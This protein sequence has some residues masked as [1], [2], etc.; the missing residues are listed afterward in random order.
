MSER[1]GES[2][3]SK[4]ELR[5]IILAGVM[6]VL[7]IVPRA[8]AEGERY[9]KTGETDKYRWECLSRSCINRTKA[10]MRFVFDDGRV[11]EYEGG[12]NEKGQRH[13]CQSTSKKN[14]R[15]YYKGPWHD[16]K[17]D[18]RACDNEGAFY[19]SSGNVYVGGWRESKEHGPGLYTLASGARYQ[20]EWRYGK[21]IATDQIH[22]SRPTGGS[23]NGNSSTSSKNYSWIDYNTGEF[24][25][26]GVNKQQNNRCK[27]NGYT[28]L[29]V[30]ACKEAV[31]SVCNY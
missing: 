26:N 14:G 3:C 30:D 8:E 27:E 28:W 17:R 22:D 7:G 20:Q 23:Q 13:G 18:T 24:S 19:Y 15:V 25:C 4:K 1:I 11:Y 9:T 10:R 29:G 5:F 12:F 16:D 6:S 21:N 2:L 31:R